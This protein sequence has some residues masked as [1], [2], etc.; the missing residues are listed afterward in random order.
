MDIIPNILSAIGSGLGIMGMSSSASAAQNIADLNYRIASY[1]ARGQRSAGAAALNLERI[2]IRSQMSEARTSLSLSLADAAMRERNAQRLRLFAEAKTKAG[3]DAM[4]RQLGQF[5]EYRSRQRSAVAASGVAMSGSPLEVMAETT[6]QM[7]L[8]IQDMA[9]ETAFQRDEVLNQATLEALGAQRD[10]TAA[11]ATFGYAKRGTSL[12][13]LGNQI[14]RQTL[15][16]Q[17]QSGMM[18]AELNR[19]SGYDQAAGTRMSAFGSAFSSSG[20][21]L[22]NLYKD[23]DLGAGIFK[24]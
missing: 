22:T 10:R 11:R 15:R 4:Q 13:L 5:D 3:R 8:S 6:A 16:S 7:K 23:K 9:N 17:Y 19:M 20:S 24:P 14:G 18:A 2:G 12:A 21:F 1:N